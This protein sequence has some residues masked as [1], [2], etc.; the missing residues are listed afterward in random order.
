MSAHPHDVHPHGE[1]VNEDVHHEESDINVRAILWFVGI[2]TAITVGIQAA[3]VGMFKGLDWYEARNEPYV[4][5]LSRGPAQAADFP[6]PRL[7]T[8]PWTDLRLFRAEQNQHLNSYG[9]VDEKLGVARIP[10]AKAKELLLQRG[11]P[12]RP[13]L[14]A[15]RE[16]TN[17]AATGESSGGRSLPGG[18]ADKTGPAG[19][20]GFVSPDA[21]ATPEPKKP[22]GG[23]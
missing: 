3:M 18:L 13:E 22:G 1:L 16:G 4:T 8:T 15:D 11:L 17:V 14:A 20:G 21:A 7:Q 23:L 5:P 6:E 9:W 19:G 10:I 2:L 12:V